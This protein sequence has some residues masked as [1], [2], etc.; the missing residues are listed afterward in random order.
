MEVTEPPLTEPRAKT[1]HVC[2]SSEHLKAECPRAIE[3]RKLEAWAIESFRARAK[4]AGHSLEERLRR[5]LIETA[6]QHRQALIDEIGAFR[7]GLRA[8]HGRCPIRL[9]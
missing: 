9:P 1:C 2:G 4:A 5:L 7:Q 3:I 8:Q 6:R